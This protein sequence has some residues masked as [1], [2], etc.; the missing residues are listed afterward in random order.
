V[1]GR[2]NWSRARHQKPTE[3]AFP[4]DALARRAAD[5]ERRWKGGERQPA[6]KVVSR[7][8]SPADLP[9]YDDLGALDSVDPSRL[10]AARF[11]VAYTDGSAAPNPGRAGWGAFIETDCGTVEMSG[12]ARRSTNNRAE[13]MGAIAVLEALP[14]SCGIEIVSDSKYLI[15]GA[16]KWIGGWRR[17][18]WQ[19]QSGPIPNADLWQRLEAAMTGRKIA[20]R[21]CRGH[22][23]NARNER[24]DRLATQGREQVAAS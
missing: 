4:T 22:N 15:D 20:W 6:L 5:A 12:G 9:V 13:L 8:P 7:N 24:A 16:T 19:R 18:N 10:A 23:S 17:R 11:A 2:M 21:W 3:Q 1:M 14:N